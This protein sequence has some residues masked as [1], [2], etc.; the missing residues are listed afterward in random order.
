MEWKDLILQFLIANLQSKKAKILSKRYPITSLVILFFLT[1]GGLLLSSL[2]RIGSLSIF[3]KT[4]DRPGLQFEHLS[5][6]D[7]LIV[8]I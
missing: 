4:Q 8:F 6:F 2:A 7:L 1:Q 5:V 3:V